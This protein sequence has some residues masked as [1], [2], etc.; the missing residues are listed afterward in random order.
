M[1]TTVEMSRTT[2]FAGLRLQ[3]SFYVSPQPSCG[4]A[5]NTAVRER[6]LPSNPARGLRLEF[7]VGARPVVWTEQAVAE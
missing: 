6:L 7:G 2:L 1:F 3:G 4:A 5:L